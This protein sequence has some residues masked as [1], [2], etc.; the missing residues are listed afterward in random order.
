MNA[1]ADP[2]NA[3]IT[4]LDEPLRLDRDGP[5]AG[6][7]LLVKDLIDTEG[8]RTTY[9]SRVYADHVPD[10]NAIVVDARA[11]RRRHGHRQ[12]EPRR[13][14]V[15]G[16][17]HERVVRDGA[18]P[19][20]AGP[21]HRRV[22]ERQRGGDRGRDLRPRDRHGHGLLD[23]SARRRLRD[24]RAQDPARE[25][26]D[27]R[28]VPALPVLRH[29][30]AARAIGRATSRRSGR[31]SRGGASPSRA[32]PGAR[33]ASCGARRTSRTDARPRRAMRPRHGSDRLEALGARVVEAEMPGPPAD[34]WPVFLH[35]AARSHAATFPSRADEYGR[36]DPREARGRAT[37]SIRTP[38]SRATGRC[39][40]GG[41]SSPR[42][43]ST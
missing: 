43:T 25:R 16:A 8:I 31:C 1:R 39:S 28:R 5:L 22:V 7:T 18:Q 38:S 21:H 33:S 32:S 12:G 15:G 20:Q 37:A 14:R 41:G 29:R 27:R 2:L 3:C 19:G 42:S 40:P 11:G 13:V 10:R 24:R 4:W 35:E 26:P 30:R 17:R 34:T 9:G 36:G 6:R 23:P